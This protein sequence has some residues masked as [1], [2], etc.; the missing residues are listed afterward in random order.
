[1]I[2]LCNSEQR[3]EGTDA[4]G[5]L[6]DHLKELAKLIGWLAITVVAC[7]AVYAGV[8]QLPEQYDPFEPFSV[9]APVSA[10]SAFKIA[11]LEQDIAR[12]HATLDAAGI[13]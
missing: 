1:M 11:R 10:L 3:G 6:L 7:I 12:C 13:A 8:R 9:D 5:D 4:E 2:R